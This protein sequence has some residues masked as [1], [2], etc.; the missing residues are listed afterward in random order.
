MIFIFYGLI[1]SSENKF[2]SINTLKTNLFCNL[3]LLMDEWISAIENPWSAI[4]H[5]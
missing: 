3:I 4:F 5:G 1:S 2:N